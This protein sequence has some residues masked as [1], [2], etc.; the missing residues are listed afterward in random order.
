MYVF[1]FLDLKSNFFN[2]NLINL[3]KIIFM[4]SILQT[5][6]N[7]SITNFILIFLYLK[8]NFKNDNSFN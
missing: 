7:I 5:L 4:T 1:T 3:N 2:G 8:S 6:D